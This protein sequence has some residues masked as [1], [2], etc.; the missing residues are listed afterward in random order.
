MFLQEVRGS[1][2][3]TFSILLFFNVSSLRVGYSVKSF[4]EESSR[5]H[6]KPLTNF[7]QAK[8]FRVWEDEAKLKDLL[9]Y[10]PVM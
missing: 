10:R 4:N 8:D 2:D 3:S 1:N 6:N 7:N 9:F 5:L